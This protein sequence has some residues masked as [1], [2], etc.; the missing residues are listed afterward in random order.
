[1]ISRHRF[2]KILLTLYLIGVND[3]PGRKDKYPGVIN[4]LTA[5]TQQ[6]LEN[7]LLLKQ[8]IVVG[9]QH[10]GVKKDNANISRTIRCRVIYKG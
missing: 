3:L 6:T 7:S 2:T 5:M 4:K 10:T 9:I 1:M 8:T